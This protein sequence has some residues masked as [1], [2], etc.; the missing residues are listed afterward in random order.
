[1]CDVM[2]W[3]DMMAIKFYNFHILKKLCID[4]KSCSMMWY[5]VVIDMIWSDKCMWCD[6]IWHNGQNDMIR[7]KN[8][9]FNIIKMK[10]EE[11]LQ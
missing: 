9:V 10:E 6:S 1:M 8:A 3:G 11:V 5:D 2:T 7:L 4:I